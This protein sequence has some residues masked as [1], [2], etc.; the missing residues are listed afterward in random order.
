MPTK[1][2]LAIKKSEEIT[3]EERRVKAGG[4]LFHWVRRSFI[5]G[6]RFLPKRG[7][8]QHTRAEG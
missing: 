4:R 8:R 6:C 1:G 3:R 5:A 2:R 7:D